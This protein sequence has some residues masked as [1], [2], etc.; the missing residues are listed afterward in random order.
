[1]QNF[2]NHAK[3]FLGA[4]SPKGFVS[5]FDQLY[6]PEDSWFCYILKGGPGTGKSTIMKKAAKAAEKLGIDLELIY[7]S[8]DPNSLDAVIFPTIKV[9]IVDGTAPHTLDPIYPGVS[10]KI[11]NLGSAWD[12]NKLT[13]VSDD[14]IKLTNQNSSFH[15][16]S[17]RYLEA[18]GSIENDTF[19][20]VSSSMDLPKIKAYTKRLSKK[21][22]KKTLDESG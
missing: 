17:K 19:K 14:I 15:K 6:D 18:C 4:N 8:S 1:M 21:L 13:D 10:E 22:F 9:C 3:F 20:I 16:R 12:N 7:C 2:I 5:R 11:I